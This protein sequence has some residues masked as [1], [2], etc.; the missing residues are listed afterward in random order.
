MRGEPPEG[1]LHW[2][3]TQADGPII[4]G[5]TIQLHT[6]KSAN[7]SNR[8]NLFL[9]LISFVLII[10][11]IIFTKQNYFFIKLKNHKNRIRVFIIK[12]NF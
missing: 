1:Q 3:H 8:P 9:F 5:L 7:N 2:I 12:I 11:F 4:M 10:C 6:P